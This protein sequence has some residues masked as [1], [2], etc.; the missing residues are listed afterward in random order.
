M[1][2]LGWA[3]MSGRLTRLTGVLT[4]LAVSGYRS[5]R[6]VVV[7]LGRLT[8]V[9]GANGAGKSNL[10]RA[11]RLLTDVA[12]GE[13]IAGLAREGGLSSTLWAGPEVITR[14]MRA[15]EIPVQGTA[16]AGPIRV[17]LGFGS[18][19]L[20]YAIDLGLP[21]PD[22]ASFFGRDPEIKAEHVWAGHAPRRSAMLTQ[23]HGAVLTTREGAEWA[24][25]SRSLLPHDSML[26]QIADPD[27][28]PELRGLRG[29][30]RSWRFYDA[31]RTD[32]GAPAR[33][34]MVATRTPV[35]AGDGSDLAAALA[36][37]IENG[38][39]EL[40]ERT[41]AD[42]LAGSRLAIELDAGL[43]TLVLHQPGMLR[44]LRADE[45]SDGTLRFLMLTAALLSPRPPGL[46]VL[47]EP[48]TSL[49]PS[50]YAPL[51]RLIRAS[52]ASTQVLVVTHASPL[53]D[54]LTAGGEE[55]DDVVHIELVKELGET[56]VAGGGMLST[57]PW[58][59]PKR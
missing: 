26:S 55:E 36:T 11:L 22:P 59:W 13:A 19:D 38:S 34:P 31:W 47:N 24:E 28:A 54:G 17:Q 5:L 56:R 1:I 30:L 32:P 52:A 48:E 23:R 37:I 25:V 18:D 27:R 58:T 14:A 7:G 43:L 2:D 40:L 50:L 45:L 49:H 53:V 15:G 8:V 42:A 57:P 12:D 39:R 6:D 9:T 46:F 51:A 10:Y 41:I 33:R 21:R 35:L 4:T 29:Q 44:G 20:G 16:R 3:G